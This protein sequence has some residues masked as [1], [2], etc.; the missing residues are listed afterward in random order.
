MA[1]QTT[2]QKPLSSMEQLALWEVT[3]SEESD[4]VVFD[5]V[6]ATTVSEVDKIEAGQ[7]PEWLLNEILRDNKDRPKNIE[8]GEAKAAIVGG[9]DYTI[10]YGKG[11][12]GQ[13]FYLVPELY[14]GMLSAFDLD[15][16]ANLIGK[17]VPL[18]CTN[19]D[20][21]VYTNTVDMPSYFGYNDPH[22]VADVIDE[23]PD[24][25]TMA[26]SERTIRLQDDDR[27]EALDDGLVALYGV[28]G[29]LTAF[30]LPDY[31]GLGKYQGY[32]VLVSLVLSFVLLYFHTKYINVRIKR[33]H[34]KRE[35]AN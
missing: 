13:V 14:E 23:M 4:E 9:L 5:S 20:K 25:F 27:L 22:R 24:A 18:M 21:L 32:F 29:L 26:S 7:A 3:E 11:E 2:E 19:G 30:F 8:S 28:I 1:K 6:N 35:A 15:C 17:R 31:V 34:L 10:F 12:D 16:A 33:W